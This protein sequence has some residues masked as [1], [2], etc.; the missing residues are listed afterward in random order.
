MNMESAKQHV[1]NFKEKVEKYIDMCTE[2]GEPDYDIKVSKM[3][4][5]F[6]SMIKAQEDLYD[7][8]KKLQDALKELEKKAAKIKIKTKDQSSCLIF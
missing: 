8:L 6:E 7:S 5:T 2:S 4:K 1:K 3:H